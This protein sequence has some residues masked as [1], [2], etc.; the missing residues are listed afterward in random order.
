MS[1]SKVDFREFALATIDAAE[2]SLSSYEDEQY[3]A[4][5]GMEIYLFLA[6][7]ARTKVV[8]VVG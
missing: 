3:A 6:L 1:I 8:A 4:A 2:Q 7:C 5:F